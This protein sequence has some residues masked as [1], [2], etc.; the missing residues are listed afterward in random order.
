MW[1]LMIIRFPRSLFHGKDN[2]YVYDT[3]DIRLHD[4]D[5]LAYYE[6]LP[7]P[8]QGIGCR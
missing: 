3:T 4:E 6:H 7:V 2:T 5:Y 8:L 1:G